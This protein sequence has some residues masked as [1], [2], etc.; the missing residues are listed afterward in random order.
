MQNIYEVP[1]SSQQKLCSLRRTS[2]YFGGILLS[3]FLL[4]VCAFWTSQS[5]HFL[6]YIRQVSSSGWRVDGLLV[7]RGR[8]GWAKLGERMDE[9][10]GELLKESSEG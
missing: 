4:C 6:S 10:L 5:L 1:V 9:A 7:E 3:L 8:V 2:S